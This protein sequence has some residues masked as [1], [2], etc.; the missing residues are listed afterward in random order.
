MIRREHRQALVAA[1]FKLNTAYKDRDHNSAQ[2]AI[3][4]ISRGGLRFFS[5]DIFCI[6]DLISVSIY[7]D[8][9]IIH[10]AKCRICYFE[11]DKVADHGDFYGLSF[12]DNFIDMKFCDS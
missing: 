2:Y 8:K 7:I 10:H 1:Y 11:H 12:I 3:D 6:G 5:H 4:N 9:Q